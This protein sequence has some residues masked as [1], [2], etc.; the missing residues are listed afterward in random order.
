M[1][2]LDQAKYEIKRARARVGNVSRWKGKDSQDY[3][4]ASNE[5]NR[6][7]AIK[8]LEESRPYLKYLNEDDVNQWLTELELQTI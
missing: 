2:K 8:F 1:T 5:A 7:Q 6:W 4:E 3:K